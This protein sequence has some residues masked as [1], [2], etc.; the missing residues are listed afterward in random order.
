MKISRYSRK[1]CLSVGDNQVVL[2]GGM[3]DKPE[4]GYE[5]FVSVLRHY[6]IN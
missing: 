1:S 4:G 6:F 3:S 2:V 5:V